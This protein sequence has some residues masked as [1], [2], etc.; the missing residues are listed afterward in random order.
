MLNI[1]TMTVGMAQANCYIVHNEI[2]ALIVDP[3]GESYRIQDTIERL[4]VKPIAILLTHTHYDHIGALDDIRDTYNIPV[5]VAA[6][7]SEWLFDPMKNLSSHVGEEITTR[8]AEELFVIGEQ[9]TISDFT[10][11][12]LPTPGHSPGGVS[13]VFEEAD[14]VITG[15]ALFGGSIGRTDFPGSNHAQLLNAIREQLFT[16]PD[17]YT[18]YPG[19][20]GRSTIGHEKNHNPFF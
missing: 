14:F 8:P 15:D 3:G 1:E 16:L 7:E 9:M 13:F 6:A 18:I 4:D 11:K 20:M 19:H 10:F 17:H 2:D 12:V 5:W